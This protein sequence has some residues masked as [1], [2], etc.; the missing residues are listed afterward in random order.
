MSANLDAGFTRSSAALA[1]VAAGLWFWPTVVSVMDDKGDTGAKWLE[2]DTRTG[3]TVDV[4]RTVHAK[5][6]RNRWAAGA[7]GLSVLCQALATALGRL[8][9]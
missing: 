7:T 8:S 5:A 6:Y 9:S 1:F 4:H 3:K 2:T